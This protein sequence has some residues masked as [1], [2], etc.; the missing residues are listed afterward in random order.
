MNISFTQSERAKVATALRIAGYKPSVKNVDGVLVAL[1]GNMETESFPDIIK[2]IPSIADMAD[3]E[4]ILS[5]EASEMIAHLKDGWDYYNVLNG[6]VMWSWLAED[7]PAVNPEVF[8]KS[9]MPLEDACALAA[10]PG[11]ESFDDIIKDYLV[12]HGDRSDVNEP[13]EPDGL[14]SY[15][16]AEP[17]WIH[18][19]RDTVLAAGIARRAE[20][21]EGMSAASLNDFIPRLDARGITISDRYGIGLDDPTSKG[22][23][24]NVL[25]KTIA[26]VNSRRILDGNM[27]MSTWTFPAEGPRPWYGEWQEKQG[28][29]IADFYKTMTDEPGWGPCS[30]ERVDASFAAALDEYPEDRRADGRWKEERCPTYLTHG[31]LARDEKGSGI[32]GA[33]YELDDGGY[34]YNLAYG[35]IS[36]PLVGAGDL[37]ETRYADTLDGA[38][39]GLVEL[40]ATLA[41]SVKLATAETKKATAYLSSSETLAR[42]DAAIAHAEAG[43]HAKVSTTSHMNITR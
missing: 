35:D 37:A 8:F 31:Y 16:L 30:K 34:N 6:R 20:L 18:A 7:Y 1:V 13:D 39:L 40:G 38:R 11:V 2:N 21:S 27:T 28:G 32:I 4:K 24:Y 3:L 10:K 22:A 33:V 29:Q 12:H 19:T 43:S 36:A 17:G 42:L 26:C 15:F 41:V 25:T 14:L 23:V 5:P 9:V